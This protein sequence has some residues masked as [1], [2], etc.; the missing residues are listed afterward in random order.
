MDRKKILDSVKKAKSES[1]KRNFSQ[2]IDFILNL[3]NLD[4]KKPEHQVD[5][6]VTYPHS[7]GKKIKVCALVGPELKD[8]ASKVCDLVILADDFNKYNENKSMIKKIA[9]EYDFFIAQANIMPQ[10]AT[11][12][13]RALG[14]KNKMPNPKAGCVVPPKAN[15]KPLYDRLQK[16]ARITAKKEFII[17][18]VVGNET[19]SDEEIADN[20]NTLYTQVIH[21]LP[22]EENNIRSVYIKLTMGK[23]IKVA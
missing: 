10:V 21:H 16:T 4:F 17:H 15:L 14:P 23:P 5:I 22:N 19:M 18:T 13:G 11:T 8:E 2:R 1:K 3:K 9:K 12:F 20:I 7:L 6:F